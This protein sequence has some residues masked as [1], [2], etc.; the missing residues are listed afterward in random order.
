M[1]SNESSIVNNEL[2]FININQMFLNENGKS[3]Y[4]TIHK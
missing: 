2:L 3:V 4:V 1:H